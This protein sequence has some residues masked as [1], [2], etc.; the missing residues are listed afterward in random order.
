MVYDFLC[1]LCEK[2][3]IRFAVKSFYRREREEKYAK[4]TK[5]SVL[6]KDSGNLH[7]HLKMRI[8]QDMPPNE[9]KFCCFIWHNNGRFYKTHSKNGY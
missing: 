6:G 5:A 2:L 4:S 8:S 9:K 3:C 1:A 7:Q